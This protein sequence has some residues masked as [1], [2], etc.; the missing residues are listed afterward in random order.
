MDIR[1]RYL[2]SGLLCWGVPLVTFF[3]LYVVPVLLN[4]HGIVDIA[5]PAFVAMFL[6]VVLIILII[7]FNFVLYVRVVYSLFHGTEIGANTLTNKWRRIFICTLVFGFSNVLTLTA[8]LTVVEVKEFYI[9]VLVNLR[10]FV[11]AVALTVF[12]ILGK[13]NRELWREFINKKG[14]NKLWWK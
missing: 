10:L 12:T 2:K 7:N 13:S 11:N 6:V 1:R 8:L 5:L 3:L 4:V 9:I 14:L